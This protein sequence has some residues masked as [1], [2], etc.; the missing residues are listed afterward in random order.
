MT[1]IPLEGGEKQKMTGEQMLAK[2]STSVD[3][4]TET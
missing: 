3:I 1:R 4:T 2:E